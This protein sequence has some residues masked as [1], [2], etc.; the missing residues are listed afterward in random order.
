MDQAMEQNT[1]LEDVIMFSTLEL[2]KAI[3]KDQPLEL[4]SVQVDIVDVQGHID[5]NKETTLEKPQEKE[6]QVVHT[7]VNLP[8]A[9]T[10]TKSH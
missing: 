8:S 1:F 2:E 6:E 4:I 9:S 3:V 7:L 5:Q 10:P